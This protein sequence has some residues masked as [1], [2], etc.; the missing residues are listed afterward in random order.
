M[1]AIITV[2]FKLLNLCNPEDLK[3]TGMTFEEMVRGLILEEG[4]FGLA[5]DDSDIL[6]IESIEP[7]Q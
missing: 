1:D 7:G 4:I 5:E 6:S 2:K 3:T